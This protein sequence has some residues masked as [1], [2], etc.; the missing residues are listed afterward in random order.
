MCLCIC[1]C[2]LFFIVFF[3]LF[4]GCACVQVCHCGLAKAATAH[5]MDTNELIWLCV[6][7]LCRLTC[8]GTQR[9]QRHMSYTQQGRHAATLCIFTQEVEC[10][11]FSSLTLSFP[12]LLHHCLLKNSCSCAHVAHTPRTSCNTVFSSYRASA[13]HTDSPFAH[14]L[15]LSRAP[16]CMLMCTC[17]MHIWHVVQRCSLLP[18]N[19]RNRGSTGVVSALIPLRS[20]PLQS[21]A[22]MHTCTRDLNSKDIVLSHSLSPRNK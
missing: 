19:G 18:C 4:F 13:V 21:N 15:Q 5:V 10:S 1:V 22:R 17:R 9:L 6:C 11:R 3:I 7:V 16:A 20:H 2:S 14:L 12:P 8:A